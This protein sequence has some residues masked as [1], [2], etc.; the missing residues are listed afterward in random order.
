M[1]HEHIRWLKALILELEALRYQVRGALAR[2]NESFKFDARAT[3]L[4]RAAWGE[5]EALE[6]QTH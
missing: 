6:R 2:P 3:D 4:A 1:E 5:M